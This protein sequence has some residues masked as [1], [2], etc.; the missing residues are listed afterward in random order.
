VPINDFDP[1]LKLMARLVPRR[2]V[3]PSTLRLMRRLVPLMGLPGG[4]PDE[5]LTL[6][7]GAKVRLHRPAKGG[8]GA[9]LLWLHGGGYIMGAPVVDDGLCRRFADTLGITV[10]A[11]GYR[12]AP[13][14]PYPAGLDDAY[15]ALEWLSGL[16]AVDPSRVAIGGESGGAGLAA[17]L[18]IR[19]R[20]RGTIAPALQVLAYPMLDDRSSDR[21]DGYHPHHR[22]WNQQTNRYGWSSYLAG[23]DPDTAVPARCADLSGVAPAWLGVGTFDLF[24][25][26]NVAYAA[27]LTAAGVPCHLEVVPGAFHAFD[28]FAPKATVS[29][30]FFA[31]ECAALRGALGANVRS[32]Q[33]QTAPE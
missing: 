9:A 12:L 26:E 17:A 19:A 7:N 33:E 25:D 29:Q 5:V 13:E 10:A 1:D 4:S 8:D 22:M 14:N 23:A 6:T 2:L 16:P 32:W 20:D 3:R 31:S 24:H 11:A 18:A 30:A 27:R 21:P 15:F 28:V